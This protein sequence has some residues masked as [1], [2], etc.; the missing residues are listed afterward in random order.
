MLSLHNHVD[1]RG[2]FCVHGV[3]TP[4][5]LLHKSKLWEQNHPLMRALCSV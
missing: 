3:G 2:Q 5:V 1:N 4:H